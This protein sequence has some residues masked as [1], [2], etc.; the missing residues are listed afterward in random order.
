MVL[1]HPTDFHKD[2]S[3]VVK[4]VVGMPGDRIGV[5]GRLEAEDVGAGKVWVEG[6]NA[7]MSRDS[8]AYGQVSAGLSEGK[9]LAVIWPPVR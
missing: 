9:V 2:Q 1:R 5:P 4:R 7:V 8:R 3:L 6:D